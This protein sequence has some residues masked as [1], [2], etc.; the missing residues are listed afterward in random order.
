MI[1]E[2]KYSL[3]KEIK[4]RV[5]AL[6]AEQRSAEA[7]R[8]LSA[9]SADPH[10]IEAQRVLIYNPLPDEINV[11]PILERFKSEKRF[12]MPV[13]DGD[14][15]KILPYTSE[16]HIGAFNIS[17]PVGSDY[18]SISDIDLVIVPGVGFSSD[19]CRLGRGRGYY[20]RLLSGATCYKIGV[21]FEC[22]KNPDIGVVSEPHDV[23][24][25][26]IL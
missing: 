11:L 21:C 3:R 15:L 17:E 10:F 22:Q 19:G 14:N 25:D 16:Q 8:L 18:I 9:I 1:A 2:T 6:S 24:M 13:V 20:D 12:F 4:E 5:R 26:T 23:R 7:L